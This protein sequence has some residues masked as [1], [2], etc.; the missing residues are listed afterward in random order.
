M[1]EITWS[2]L[3]TFFTLVLAG[4]LF[5]SVNSA[6]LVCKLM[7]LPDP[8]ESGSK[9]PG[10]TNML[11]LG[12]KTAAI[13]T[14]FGDML[15]G[16]LPVLIGGFMNLQGFGLGMVGLAAFL[17]HLYPVFFNFQGGKG[18]ATA[19]GVLLAISWPVG[20]CALGTWVIIAAIFRYSSLA[21]LITALLIP[22][23][24]ELFGNGEAL[25]PMSAI[26]LVLIV[27]HQANIKRLLKGNESKIG[28]K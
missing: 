28:Q 19:F 11:R 10:T 5:G 6:I 16:F 23:Y 14:L 27:R 4:Y 12:G 8:R 2:L 13:I 3:L 17:G 24:L 15:K 18:V 9:N 7:G 1:P 20:L 26:C 22:L 21:A 25:L